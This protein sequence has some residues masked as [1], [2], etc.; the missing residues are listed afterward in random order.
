MRFSVWNTISRP[1][2]GKGQLSKVSGWRLLMLGVALLYCTIWCVVSSISLDLWSKP[3]ET[4]LAGCFVH[5][6]N[7]ADGRELV[8][9]DL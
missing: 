1:G 3:G 4:A 9:L 6:Q 2:A 5:A 8:Y 7:E